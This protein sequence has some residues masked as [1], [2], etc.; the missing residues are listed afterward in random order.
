MP[1]LHMIAPCAAEFIGTLILVFTAGCC[2]LAPA[3][4]VWAPSAIACALMVAVYSTAYVS[5]GNVN[6]AV[7]LSLA[8]IGKLSW[9]VALAYSLCQWAAGLA[10]GFCFY[11]IFPGSFELGPTDPWSPE[12]CLLAECIY[13]TVLCFT[14]INC[15]VSQRNN[16]VD[17]GNQFFGLAIGF[18]IIAGGY[19]VGTVSGA[20][21]NPAIVLGLSGSGANHGIQWGISWMLAEFLGAAIA[22][23]LYR[24]VRSEEFCSENWQVLEEFRPKLPARCFC[25]F[26]GTFILALTIGLNLTGASPATAWSGAAAMMCMM[27]A[28]RNVS[29]SHFNPAVTFAVLFSGRGKLSPI[30]GLAYLLSQFLGAGCAGM[31]YAAF[32]SA[33]PNSNISYSLGPVGNYSPVAAGVIELA[34]TAIL[35]YVALA[36]ATIFTPRSWQTRN[37]FYSSLAIAS[38]VTLG[39]IAGASVSGGVLN[40]AVALSISVGSWV[41]HGAAK[42]HPFTNCIFYSLWQLAGGLAA[43]VAFRISHSS[44]FGK[45]ELTL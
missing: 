36:C 19:A 38:C 33:G 6:P 1:V 37:N 11:A 29:G 13:T 3:E 18:V 23:L 10:A 9:R 16:P 27:Y 20:L 42:L 28:L 45:E 5:G 17:D 14:V 32:H 43:A 15:A 26:L 8:L 21:F 44:E 12:F 31:L 22:A 7:S 2:T 34:F 4:P 41:H 30:D 24:L 40:P 35:C 39:G 25:E